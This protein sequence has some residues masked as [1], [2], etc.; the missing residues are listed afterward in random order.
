MF[1]AAPRAERDSILL[2]GIDYR[3]HFKGQPR[4]KNEAGISWAPRGNYL[5]E[6]LKSAKRYAES[7]E[8]PMDVWEVDTRGLKLYTDHAWYGGWYC[9]AKIGPERIVRV[10]D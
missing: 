1:H 3:C 6:R 2:H 5:D 7:H 8:I 10:R 4:P 9:R